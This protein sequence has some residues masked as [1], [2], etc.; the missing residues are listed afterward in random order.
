MNTVAC[1]VVCKFCTLGLTNLVN[2]SGPRAFG[3][4]HELFANFYDPYCSFK[5]NASKEETNSL[6]SHVVSLA[7]YHMLLL[8]QDNI[9]SYT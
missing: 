1:K 6:S 5:D 4:G 2:F 9:R 7:S 8:I 3:N